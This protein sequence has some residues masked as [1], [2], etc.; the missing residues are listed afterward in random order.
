[1]G[2]PMTQMDIGSMY[3]MMPPGHMGMVM[4]P[5]APNMNMLGGSFGGS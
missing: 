5:M 2:T 3:G 1:M 4:N